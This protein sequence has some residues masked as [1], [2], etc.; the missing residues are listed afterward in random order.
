MKITEN[1]LAV[2]AALYP[3]LVECAREPSLLTLTYGELIRRAQ[4]RYPNVA[5]VQRTIPVGVGRRLEVV[6][7]FL[8]EREL[9]DL[10]SLVVNVDTGEVGA[11]FNANPDAVRKQVAAF[12]WS[13]V[14]DEFHLHIAGLQDT[15]A[16][17]K[18]PRL[19]HDQAKALMSSYY[20]EHRGKLPKSITSHRDR[21]IALI[22]DGI[23]VEEAF[24]RVAR[25]LN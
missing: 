14:S 23:P 15:I 16:T 13:S 9:P 2:A 8:R 7:I 24:S 10:T 22:Q 11:G 4:A 19:K 3:I 25:D 17:A 18:R 6:R 1:D 5:A 20:L 12:D 21:L